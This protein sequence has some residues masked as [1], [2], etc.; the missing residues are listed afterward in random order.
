[1]ASRSPAPGE[2]VQVDVKFVR[3]GG[4]RAYQYTALDDCTRF[5]VLRLYRQLN[6]RSSQD[7]LAEM[8]RTFPFAI[9]KIQTDH[10]AEFSFAFVLAVERRG[11]RH[12]YIRPRCP[13]QNGKVERSHRIDHEEFWSQ[14][15]FERFEAATAALREW[16]RVYNEQRFSMALNGRTPAEK[17]AAIL[18]A[19]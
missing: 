7:F 14:Q 6:V 17:L 1:M 2:S 19:A 16:E 12:R 9:R 18:K 11:I 15:S 3:V 5:R 4:T 8:I 13:E 10:G